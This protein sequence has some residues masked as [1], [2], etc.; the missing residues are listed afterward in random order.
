MSK[1][2]RWAPV[3]TCGDEPDGTNGACGG[4]KAV[5]ATLLAAE[6][7]LIRSDAFLARVIGP[8]YCVKGIAL[9]GVETTD[10]R[11]S[12]QRRCVISS[13][14]PDANQL[15]I[16]NPTFTIPLHLKRTMPPRENS[17]A[18]A[19]KEKK[20]ANKA[21]VDAKKAKEAEAKEAAEWQKGAKGN[22][23]AEEEQARRAEQLAKKA[24]REALLKAVR[25]A[26]GGGDSKNHT[27]RTDQTPLEL[28]CRRRKVCL[29][30]LPDQ[31][32]E[33][34]KRRPRSKT[35]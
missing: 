3:S 25:R 26:R 20:A 6:S 5:C 32:E 22:A 10:L 16:D 34:I 8:V 14:K 1:V 18:V 9:N 29:Q 11:R 24:E 17:K 23:K 33:K 28:H 30:N 7:S 13:N 12:F 21:E 27:G 4:C 31:L 19:A 2:R 35:R 15:Y